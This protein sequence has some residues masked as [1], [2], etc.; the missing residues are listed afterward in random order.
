MRSVRSILT[1][2]PTHRSLTDTDMGYNFEGVGFPYYTLRPSQWY[3][4][5]RRLAC[6][7]P[8][9]H[10]E[11][12]IQAREERGRGGGQAQGE[13]RCTWLRPTRGDRLR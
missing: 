13:A 8:S 1:H 10:S 3:V 2:G 9:D 6:W 4:G 11:V 7:P 5:P 12:G